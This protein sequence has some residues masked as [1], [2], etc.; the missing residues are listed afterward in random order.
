MQQRGSV[1][2]NPD[3]CFM[4]FLFKRCIKKI[5][6]NEIY[7]SHSC[8]ILWLLSCYDEVSSSNVFI[9]RLDLYYLKVSRLS[10]NQVN[11]T[12]RKSSLYWNI[13]NFPAMFSST[14]AFFFF[15]RS[16]A[17]DDLAQ[18]V[19][20]VMSLL[21]EVETE[22]DN[23]CSDQRSAEFYANRVLCALRHITD[24]VQHMYR[25]GGFPHT[26]VQE[27]EMLREN[28]RAIYGVIV[29]LSVMHGYSYR[30][31]VESSSGPGRPR[32][33]IPP[34]QLSCLRSEFNS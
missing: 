32:Y 18:F 22:M 8:N 15:P 4:L 1:C 13:S 28:L 24:I 14:D 19:R 9:S 21:R 7:P 23:I 3:L 29:Q 17:D 31:Q 34:E 25:S 30:P 5:S 12:L 11:H 16:T 20:T 2:H 10:S 6:R 33:V 26:E 27:L